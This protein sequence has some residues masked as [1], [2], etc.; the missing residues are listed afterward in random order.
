MD[1]DIEGYSAKGHGLIGG[2][3]GRPI[4]VPRTLDGERVSLKPSFRRLKRRAQ[5]E[6]IQERSSVRRAPFCPHFMEC[7]GCCWQHMDLDAQRAL[8]QTKIEALFGQKTSPIRAPKCSRRYRN[9]MEFSFTAG[10]WEQTI[11]LMP[12]RGGPVAVDIRDCHITDKWMAK[13]LKATRAWWRETGHRAFHMSR[14]EGA[15]RTLTLRAQRTGHKMA[16]L[17]VSGDPRFGLKRGE[18]EA[19]VNQMEKTTKD[20]LAL[21]LQIQQAVKGQPT[22]FFT[23]HLSGPSEIEEE[24]MVP[25]RDEPLRAVIG[26]STFFQPNTAGAELIIESVGEAL[27][28]AKPGLLI[29]LYCGS[30]L[31]GMSQAHRFE[32]VLGIELIPEAVLDGELALKRSGIEN[33]EFLHGSS[34]D[35]LKREKKRAEA[36]IIDPPRCGCLDAIEEIVALEAAHLVYVS[37][38]PKTQ[39]VDVDR[40]KA[41]GYQIESI[42]PIDQFPHTYHV[43]NV[44]HMRRSL[45]F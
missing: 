42:S 4:E 33:M 38:N 40:L 3:S 34:A 1:V 23:M 35:V 11:G 18:I 14:G 7:G 8:K 45:A 24:V 21:Y 2:R 29:D 25:G 39:A 19:F 30:G 15:L 41:A 28:K 12:F 13:A 17:T 5:L 26:P 6:S 31:L 10:K 9:K 44:V 27:E 32:K 43:E 22:Q 16:I 36:L 20:P 37:C